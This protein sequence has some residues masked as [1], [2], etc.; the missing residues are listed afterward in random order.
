MGKALASMGTPPQPWPGEDE[1][2]VL[3]KPLRWPQP[4]ALAPWERGQALSDAGV[5]C[6]D[7]FALIL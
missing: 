5:G 3:T 2:L 7:D 1:L 6:V 4:L